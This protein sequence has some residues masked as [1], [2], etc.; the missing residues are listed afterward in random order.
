MRPERHPALDRQ[1]PLDGAE[2]SN[3]LVADRAV[4]AASLDEACL[5][6]AGSLAETD[7]HGRIGIAGLHP[8]R[9]A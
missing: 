3:M 5:K 9:S 4:A 6:P 2:T 1:R 7:E 8:L